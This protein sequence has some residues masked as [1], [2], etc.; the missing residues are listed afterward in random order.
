MH[1]SDYNFK[2]PAHRNNNLVKAESAIGIGRYQ[3]N[4]A[5][6]QLADCSQEYAQIF[7]LSVDEAKATHKIR[8]TSLQHIHPDDQDIYL[9]MFERIN[10]PQPH[11]VEYRV[12]HST[13]EIRH[14]RN[15]SVQIE[16]SRADDKKE[17]L[18]GFLLDISEL[19]DYRADIEYSAA[20]AQ[21]FEEI[22][23]IGYFIFD[24][25]NEK[26]LYVSSGFGR[27]YGVDCKE[28][29]ANIT[30]LADDLATVVEEDRAR[31]H[32]A[33]QKFLSQKKTALCSSESVERME[34]Y[35]G[36]LNQVR[37]KG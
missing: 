30:S 31:V 10:A 19:T 27:I 15:V 6:N 2:D 25:I 35:A 11:N 36:L 1:R 24:A 22:G 28:H 14:V 20:L 34:K 18:F 13:G 3:W 17:A 23:D 12:L 7:G 21:Q 16:A 37:R 9:E 32:A 26:F 33:Y 29:I 5:R 8:D 4:T